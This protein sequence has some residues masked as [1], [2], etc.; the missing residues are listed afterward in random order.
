MHPVALAVNRDIA[1][2]A[3]GV[4]E[5]LARPLRYRFGVGRAVQRAFGLWTQSAGVWWPVAAHSASG[6]RDPVLVIERAPPAGS[7]STQPGRPVL[8]GMVVV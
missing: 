2:Y 6:R 3:G 4:T 7:T 5:R 8:A 1:P